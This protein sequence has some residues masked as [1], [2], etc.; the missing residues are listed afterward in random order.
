[1]HFDSDTK[2]FTLEYELNADISLPT[3]IRVSPAAYPNGF[4]VEIGGSGGEGLE[5]AYDAAS[6]PY[7]L[8]VK[9]KGG[10][11]RGERVAGRRAGGT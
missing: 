9:Q 5:W 11:V 8:Y 10:G 4:E 2:T 1:M 3:E 7:V 6:N